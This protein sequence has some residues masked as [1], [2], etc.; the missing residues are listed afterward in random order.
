MVY[1][2]QCDKTGLIKI[3]ASDRL[4]HRVKEVQNEHHST[5][6]VLGVVDGHKQ[7]ERNLHIQFAHLRCDKEWFSPDDELVEFIT[8]RARSWEGSTAKP[9][10]IK[11][12]PKLQRYKY[13]PK[14]I[15]ASKQIDPAIARKVRYLARV[16]GTSDGEV[17]S[18]L[19]ARQLGEPATWSVTPELLEALEKPIPALTA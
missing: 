9:R 5:F 12:E 6:T 17:I 15:L 4:H 14:Q 13:A 8:R 7:E 19:L 18:L 2:L 10:R 1:F 11:H 16:S 3:G